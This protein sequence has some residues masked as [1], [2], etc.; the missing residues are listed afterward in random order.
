MKVLTGSAQGGY[1]SVQQVYHYVYIITNTVLNKYYIGSRTSKV[2]PDK[3]LGVLYFSSST[4]SSF[5]EDQRTNYHNYRYKVI[6]TL[7]SREAANKLESK[8]HYIHDVKNNKQFYNR[9]N[10]AGHFYDWWSEEAK[11]NHSE[12]MKGE[13][14]PM[15]NK[16]FSEEHKR[17]LALSRT[18][19]PRPEKFKTKLSKLMAGVN[20]PNSKK[21]NIYDYVTN[22]LVA[23]AVCIKDWCK[24]TKYTPSGLHKTA[25]ADR[26]LSSS[27]KNPLHHKG[28]YAQYI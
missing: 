28:L 12:R 1:M 19:K 3:D 25:R 2:L 14:N 23:S 11:A 6:A 8:L 10:A 24:N 15:F 26:S 5:I 18:G 4:D 27:S 7:A 16:K 9:A 13:K 22:E 17:K 21:A 20:N